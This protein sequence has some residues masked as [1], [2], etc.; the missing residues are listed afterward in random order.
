[1]DNTVGAVAGLAV[2]AALAAGCVS[3]LVADE[4]CQTYN[5]AGWGTT[6][7][8]ELLTVSSLLLQ[9]DGRFG[10]NGPTHPADPNGISIQNSICVETPPAV[11]LAVVLSDAEIDRRF[12]ELQQ[13]NA[14]A[15]AVE[16]QRRADRDNERGTNYTCKRTRPQILRSIDDAYNAASNPAQERAALLAITKELAKCVWSENE[17]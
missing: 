11:V 2:V 3:M 8:N 4:Q 14:A 7:R 13:A 9:E 1:M 5:T 17:R 10:A 15:A 16:D 6:K 12:L